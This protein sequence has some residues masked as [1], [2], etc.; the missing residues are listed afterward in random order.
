MATHTPGPY[1]VDTE[2]RARWADNDAILVFAPDGKTP[3]AAAAD[4]NRFDRDDEVK[5]NARLLA[6]APDL[7]WALE[8]LV[9]EFGARLSDGK[10]VG[11]TVAAMNRALQLVKAA[12]HAIDKARGQ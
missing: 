9:E 6:A 8:S 10:P 7:L 5:A 1:S 11:Y 3:V 2:R 4:F 12:E